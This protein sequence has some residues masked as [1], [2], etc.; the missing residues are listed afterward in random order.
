MIEREPAVEDSS[1]SRSGSLT[2]LLAKIFVGAIEDH[3][4]NSIFSKRAEFIQVSVSTL[5]ILRARS[6]IVRC[7]SEPST[8]LLSTSEK[9]ITIL[10]F[11]LSGTVSLKTISWYSYYS[12]Q[13]VYVRRYASSVKHLCDELRS[14]PSI[15]HHFCDSFC[16]CFIHNAS[17]SRL[18][19]LD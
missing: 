4:A 1:Q 7:S 17:G 11:C 8:S 18:H 3:R 12:C 15:S 5:A 13:L 16:Y 9:T 2:S 14:T 19:G 6:R 10:F